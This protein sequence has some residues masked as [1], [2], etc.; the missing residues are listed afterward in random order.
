MD[1]VKS[2]FVGWLY[3]YYCYLRVLYDIALGLVHT[4]HVN[5]KWA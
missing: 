5:N 4:S 3:L 1:A 2:V